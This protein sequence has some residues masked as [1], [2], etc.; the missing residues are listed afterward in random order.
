M[1]SP[2]HIL[3]YTFQVLIRQCVKIFLLL[4]TAIKKHANHSRNQRIT[5]SKRASRLIGNILFP[6]KNRFFLKIVKNNFNNLT[7][8]I[9]YL[10]RTF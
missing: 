1:S 9:T 2:D 8:L 6:L 3:M 7:C 10:L 5:Y 4:S